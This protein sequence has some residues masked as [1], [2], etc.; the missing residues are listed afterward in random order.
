MSNED[1]STKVAY[2]GMIA[3]A[4]IFALLFSLPN[5]F[6]CSGCAPRYAA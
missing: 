4:V 3:F 1:D 2:I 6:L 5:T